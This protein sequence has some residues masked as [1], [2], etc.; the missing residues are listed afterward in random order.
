MKTRV[1]FSEKK[2]YHPTIA[3]NATY[4]V[5]CRSTISLSTAL[6]LP[7]LLCSPFPLLLLWE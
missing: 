3:T 5:V 4:Q 1:I 7:P 2:F 6:K